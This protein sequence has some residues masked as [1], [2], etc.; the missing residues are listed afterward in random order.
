MNGGQGDFTRGCG[1][2]CCLTPN[3]YRRFLQAPDS[4]PVCAPRRLAR[5]RRLAASSQAIHCAMADA[6]TRIKASHNKLDSAFPP[7]DKLEI[8]SL[9]TVTRASPSLCDTD[10]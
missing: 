5:P 10:R 1:G 8:P 9:S 2:L 6:M 4:E 7:C 3:A